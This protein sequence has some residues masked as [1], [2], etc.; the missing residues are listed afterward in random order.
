MKPRIDNTQR[1]C[2]KETMQKWL[3]PS[4]TPTYFA[5]RNMRSRC[6]NKND[7]SFGNYGGRGITVCERWR[8]DYDAF[9]EDMGL[10][11][12]GFTLEREDSN[13]NY[14]PQNCR[15]ATYHD[16][17]NNRPGFNRVIEFAGREQTLAQWA[18]EFGITPEGLS[19]RLRRMAF[20]RAMVPGRLVNWAPGQHGTISTYTN[21]K[22]R[23]E[24]CR[25]AKRQSRRK[26]A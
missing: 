1:C 21:R 19:D 14:E 9:V 26:Q 2:Q 17:M 25:E 18:A 6:Y 4:G 20:T 23:C 12:D 24:L 10:R 8:E 15:W 16:Q 22:C 7:I 5:W 13:G 11:P 3:K